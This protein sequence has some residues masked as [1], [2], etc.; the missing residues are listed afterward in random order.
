MSQSSTVLEHG[1]SDISECKLN[2]IGSSPDQSCHLAGPSKFQQAQGVEILLGQL[3]E[4]TA[5]LETS[6][7][8]C[9]ELTGQV[10]QLQKDLQDAHDFI[11]ALQ[12]RRPI[13]TPAQAAED[14]KSLCLNVENWVQTTLCDVLDERRIPLSKGISPEQVEMFFSLISPAGQSAFQTPDS[15]EY[16]IIAAIMGFLCREIFDRGFWCPI[17]DGSLNMLDS[18]ENSMRNL[19]PRRGKT[20]P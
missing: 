12:P 17:E 2:P 11:F 19:E 3:T 1:G 5:K 10:K 8:Q 4:T 15:D 9:R 16:N 6:D 20:K 18:I 14:Y 7:A 13:I